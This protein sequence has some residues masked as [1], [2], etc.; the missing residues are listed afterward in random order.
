MSA[1]LGLSLFVGIGGVAL[2]IDDHADQSVS[3]HK[4]KLSYL[5]GKVLLAHGAPVRDANI[6]VYD[7]Y[8]KDITNNVLGFSEPG[9]CR[10]SYRRCT[11]ASGSFA[12]P[13]VASLPRKIRVVATGGT[14]NGVVSNI[15]LSHRIE[16]HSDMTHGVRLN[17]AST[18]YDRLRFKGFNADKA[19]AA[20]R[21]VLKLPDWANFGTHLYLSPVYLSGSSLLSTS[22][23]HGGLRLALAN[24]ISSARWGR[25]S[26]WIRDAQSGNGDAQKMLLAAPEAPTT[27]SSFELAE[28]PEWGKTIL[29]GIAGNLVGAGVN[30]L[31]GEVGL[32][33]TANSLASIQSDLSQISSQLAGLAAAINSV[34][35]QV[36]AD[37]NNLKL[38]GQC[39]YYNQSA[40]TYWASVSGLSGELIAYIEDLSIIAGYGLGLESLATA[41]TAWNNLNVSGNSLASG[42]GLDVLINAMSGINSPPNQPKGIIANIVSA[43]SPCALQQ[44]K[45][46]LNSG[47]KALYSSS[48][49]WAMGVMLMAATIQENYN[50]NGTWQCQSS[51]VGGGSGRSSLFCPSGQYAY[52]SQVAAGTHA[53]GTTPSDIY[54]ALNNVYP[55]TIPNGVS[56]DLRSGQIWTRYAV[57]PQN[58]SSTGTVNQPSIINGL[59]NWRLATKPE[60][61][62]LTKDVPSGTYAADWLASKTTA[63]TG[64]QT[65]LSLSQNLLSNNNYNDWALGVAETGGGSLGPTNFDD[66]SE[67]WIGNTFLNSTPGLY[68]GS[69]YILNSGRATNNTRAYGV[70]TND[71]VYANTCPSGTAMSNGYSFNLNYFF[72]NI[73]LPFAAGYNSPYFP[74]DGWVSLPFVVK[75]AFDLVLLDQSSGSFAS[76]ISSSRWGGDQNLVLRNSASAGDYTLIGGYHVPIS[77]SGYYLTPIV[78]QQ[79]SSPVLVGAGDS[80]PNHSAWFSIIPDNWYL[81]TA[82]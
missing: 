14:V 77:H 41:T 28:L 37:F 33:P 60:V 15:K 34:I 38:I 65:F 70:L 2:A 50:N 3:A 13:L 62:V 25:P 31:L 22:A 8:G 27:I 59:S 69:D 67:W 74:L 35:A 39:N 64:L 10:P 23:T 58:I 47:E 40:N 26:P 45:Y 29:N 32:N 24:L 46:F 18:V 66:G 75:P 11:S 79:T 71:V 17:L 68:T 43:Y 16:A 72:N 36:N 20:T 12:F 21:A 1:V 82:H 61:S 4:N 78:N 56:V 51:M 9:F 73:C 6:K 53:T 30:W 63:S 76:Q 48:F 55:Q 44:G 49:D 7:S 52:P 42:Q 19:A 81:N 57:I 5:Y 54:Y 80:V